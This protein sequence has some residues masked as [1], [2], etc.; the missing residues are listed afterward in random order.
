[1]LQNGTL[2]DGKYKIISKIGQGGMSTVYLAINERAGRQ[3]AIKEI[4]R[5]GTADFR[6]VKQSLVAET[7]LLKNLSHPNLPKIADIVDFKDSFLIVMDYIQGIT[8]Q[9]VMEMK[10]VQSQETV[11]KWAKQLCSVLGYLH[12]CNPPIIYR[13]LK[14][15]NIML[16]PDGDIVLIDFGTAREYKTEGTEDTTCLGTLGYAAPE[17]FAK[18]TQTDARTDI[19]SLGATM[20]HMLTGHNLAKPPYR[21]YPITYWNASFSG[22]LEK[23][24]TKCLM[25]DPSQRYKSAAELLYDLDHVKELDNNYKKRAFLKLT[26]FSLSVFLSFGGFFCSKKFSSY[27]GNFEKESYLEYMTRAK[28]A[29]EENK[30]I[31]EYQKAIYLNPGNSK[32]YIELL[33][34]VFLQDDCFDAKEDEKL[35]EI[36]S[37]PSITGK[38]CIEEMQENKK[39][40]DE[41]CYRLGMAYFYYYENTGS[42]SYAA[43]WLGRASLSDTLPIQIKLRAQRLYNISAYYDRIGRQSKSGELSMSYIR[44]W[45]D[46]TRA[47]SGD[48]AGTDN[49]TVALTVYNE[50]LVQLCCNFTL[51]AEDGISVS[52]MEQEVEYIEK[53]VEGE[54]FNE[55]VLGDDE[56]EQLNQLKENIKLAKKAI[57]LLE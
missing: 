13:D 17:Q 9:Q 28:E 12:S 43:R 42:K 15:G 41:F 29:D 31:K 39:E 20:Y 38:T 6:I 7:S 30:S 32:A 26:S 33:N 48:I 57:K 56:K 45:E 18:G 51:F 46:L 47:A 36:L 55:N 35:R 52:S 37:M 34:N 24:I 40:Y 11:I 19:Y 44:F 4:R 54:N 27:A 53:T 50:V 22:G 23:I 16:K 25:S 10:G 14:P 49:V 21:I 2:I 3:W 5:D 8:L 1:M